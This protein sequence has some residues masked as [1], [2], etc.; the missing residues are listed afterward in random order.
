MKK[1]ATPTLISLPFEEH[2]GSYEPLVKKT[3]D[4]DEVSSTPRVKDAPTDTTT[5]MRKT[6]E[7]HRPIAVLEAQNVV[8]VIAP[9]IPTVLPA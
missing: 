6:K 1:P 7:A 3:R 5:T 9:S 2:S 8:P 4:V